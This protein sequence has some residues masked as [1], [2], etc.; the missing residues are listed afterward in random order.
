MAKSINDSEFSRITSMEGAERYTYLVQTHV[1]G[2]QLWGLRNASGWVMASDGDDTTAIPVWPHR[3]FAEASAVGPWA[4]AA[5]ARIGP[6]KWL[7]RWLP[8]MDAEGLF[9]AVFPTPSSKA[10][11]VAA[12]EHQAHL[13]EAKEPRGCAS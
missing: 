6:L 9:V 13:L 5:A 7:K 8:A 10:V 4:G 1:H 2:H 11:F 12:L 3:R